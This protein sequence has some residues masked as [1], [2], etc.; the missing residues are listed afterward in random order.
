M[1]LKGGPAV[2]N[3]LKRKDV[4]LNMVYSVDMI[5][6]T[7]KTSRKVKS[8]VENPRTL[9]R[10]TEVEDMVLNDLL[11]WFVYSRVQEEDGLLTRYRCAGSRKVIIRKD[12]I[13]AIKRSGEQ[14]YHQIYFQRRRFGRF[15]APT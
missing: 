8:M 14:T 15:L 5:H 10:R 6:V 4:T 13:T 9:P 3:F 12:A 1:R 11:L 2:N 7:S